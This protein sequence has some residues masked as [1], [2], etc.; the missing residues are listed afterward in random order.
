MNKGRNGFLASQSGVVLIILALL[1]VPLVIFL[2][3]AIDTARL[4]ASHTQ[5]S[6]T[7]DSI[8]LGALEAYLNSTGATR[9]DKMADAFTR[10]EEIGAFGENLLVGDPS[11]TQTPSGM[12]EDPSN[13]L[14]ARASI[15]NN[16][17]Y[18][19][20]GRWWFEEPSGS[21]AAWSDDVPF[22]GCPCDGANFTGAC[23]EGINDA[24]DPEPSAF[25]IGL[26]TQQSSPIKLFFGRIVGWEAVNISSMA[27]ATLVPRKA[28]FLVDLSNSTNFET[29][30]I[31]QAGKEWLDTTKP[32]GHDLCGLWQGAAEATQY[33]LPLDTTSAPSTY[34]AAQLG[35]CKYSSDHTLDLT[36]SE[37]AGSIH[38][39][40][41]GVNPR[42][43]FLHD[44]SPRYDW[45]RFMLEDEGT[46][47]IN[48]G[49][50]VAPNLN[51]RTRAAA[52]NDPLQKT[53]FAV[54]SGDTVVFPVQRHFKGEYQ[55]FCGDNLN[56]SND[57]DGSC[58]HGYYLVDTDNM[59]GTT[60]NSHGYDT[61]GDYTD[62]E[63]TYRGPEPLSTI[64]L[65]IRSALDEMEQRLVA[66]DGVGVV[67]FDQDVLPIRV[68]PRPDASG[69]VE[70]A[71]VGTAEFDTLKEITNT[72]P[73]DANFRANLKKRLEAFIFTRWTL[74]A[75]PNTGG[76]EA[77]LADTNFVQALLKG[78][79]LVTRGAAEEVGDHMVV[80]FSDGMPVCS[81]NADVNKLD[82]L[83][84]DA[85]NKTLSPKGNRKCWV[86]D[87]DAYN[88]H[89]IS[90]EQAL[91]MIGGKVKDSAGNAYTLPTGIKSFADDH[92]TFHMFMVGK[93]VMPHTLLLKGP[94][95]CLSEVAARAGSSGSAYPYTAAELTLAQAQLDFQN[96]GNPG[97]VYLQ[98]NQRI[99]DE[100]VSPTGGMWIPIRPACDP[101]AAGIS[102][103]DCKNNA[104]QKNYFDPLCAAASGSAGSPVAVAGYTNSA[105]G[106]P[107][108]GCDPKCETQQEQVQDAIQR[109]YEQ[110]PFIL[111][112][113]EKH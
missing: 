81:Y 100:G 16:A 55:C 108:L 86:K 102:V 39:D 30:F 80:M 94:S 56:A 5:Q 17:G 91:M 15:A 101:S 107:V 105:L 109:L 20:A 71:R 69:V 76:A 26:R 4:S 23:F 67:F 78:R 89:I 49:L 111:I 9:A 41:V 7:T 48:A 66:G 50:C 84:Y 95:G 96:V 57:P 1:I 33:S 21:C 11:L 28:V 83:T 24:N 79:E 64:L 32:G 18:L 34:T 45:N 62:A 60:A 92:I 72:D 82:F 103:A 40:N 90:L 58:A 68:F 74:D 112:D 37:C 22:P 61:D 42:Y 46:G 2:A 10:A 87:A 13:T 65:A 93:A 98:P 113:S 3:F 59:V 31:P 27:I 25:K 75:N 106:T 52:E 14:A 97:N 38:C 19:W 29:H 88:N 44:G 36:V 51:L 43:D 70:L 35:H 12:L 63:E 47:Y 104:L 8:A 99:Y 6:N 110:N 54:P 85:T 53:I 73:T 77:H